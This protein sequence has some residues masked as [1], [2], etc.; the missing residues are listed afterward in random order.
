MA[1]WIVTLG[2]MG[3]GMSWFSAEAPLGGRLRGGGVGSSRLVGETS[4]RRRLRDG[5]VGTGV[6]GLEGT[7]GV[8]VG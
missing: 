2:G 5:C 4:V 1:G 3:S 7:D 8:A 6:G